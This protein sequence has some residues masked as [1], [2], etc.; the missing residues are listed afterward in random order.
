M[1]LMMLLA[2]PSS[3]CPWIGT[4]DVEATWRGRE[5]GHI[6]FP[7]LMMNCAAPRT[8]PQKTPETVRF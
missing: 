3:M 8:G 7:N 1:D 4:V 5:A 2:M 6:F